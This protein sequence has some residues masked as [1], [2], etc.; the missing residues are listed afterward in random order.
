ME[1][2]LRSAFKSRYLTQAYH[3]NA[4]IKSI[5][6]AVVLNTFFFRVMAQAPDSWT[7]KSSLPAIPRAA[8]FAFAIGDK[9]YIGGGLNFT[10]GGSLDDFWEYDPSADSWTQRADLGGGVRSGAVAFAIGDKGYALT[11][12][13][14]SGKKKDIWEYDTLLNTW[15]Q[16]TDLP[17]IE[18]NYAVAFAI[19]KKGYLGTG[20]TSD[21]FVSLNDFWQF[22]PIANTWTQKANVPGPQRSSA[23]GFAIG[24]KGYLG[25]GDTCDYLNCF[26]LN[27]FYCYDTL[28][29]T[30][31]QKANAG[32]FLRS[33]ATCFA[34]Y[35]K[36]YICTGEVN[37][38]NSNDLLE[39]DP[40]SDTWTTRASIP[41]PGKTNAIGFGTVNHGY[42][43]TGFDN[44][45]NVTADLYEY[46][47]DT[48][49][50]ATQVSEISKQVNVLISPDPVTTEAFFTIATANKNDELALEI[51]TASG[52]GISPSYLKM[53]ATGSKESVFLFKRGNLPSGVYYYS[54]KSKEYLITKGKFM[55]M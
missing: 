38:N 11:G 45:F 8:A 1:K 13:G 19:G 4:L 9:G 52:K 55:V 10:A 15:T 7:Q 30:W 18:R 48:S 5:L 40:E 44:Y 54:V 32:I 31:S 20:Y 43:G 46:T 29:N 50:V 22:D 28:T 24:G 12:A 53:K 33:N 26:S 17:A 39:Y 34:V 35:N 51:F 21:S 16:K 49:S 25:T 37:F 42:V 6:F 47:P 2:K 41:G 23:I 36:G 14:N 27:D 3:A